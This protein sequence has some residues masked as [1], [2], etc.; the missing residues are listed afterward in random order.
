MDYSS[1]EPFDRALLEAV[2]EDMS[3]WNEI[4]WWRHRAPIGARRHPPE[5]ATPS[6][7]R[8]Y[9]RVSVDASE[10]DPVHRSRRRAA[11][12]AAARA[13]K[14]QAPSGR[15]LVV[16]ELV[17][18]GGAFL[19]HALSALLVVPQIGIFGL[20]VELHQTCARLIEVKDAS[21]AARPTA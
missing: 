15:R 16:G 3:W 9:R 13:A 8:V 11:Q 5:K 18:E 1:L 6:S 2:A 19:H 12:R 21:S 20:P 4:R 17:L 10:R 14:A 7:N